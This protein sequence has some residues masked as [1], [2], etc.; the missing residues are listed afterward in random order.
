MK[1]SPRGGGGED[2]AL[3]LSLQ[4]HGSKV[5]HKAHEPFGAQLAGLEVSCPEH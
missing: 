2:R 3:R 1:Q 4:P 5:L